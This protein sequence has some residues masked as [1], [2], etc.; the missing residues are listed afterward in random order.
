MRDI[1]F[2]KDRIPRAQQVGLPANRYFN[3]AQVDNQIFDRTG[4]VRFCVLSRV[5]FET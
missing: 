1:G 2:K 3:S 5:T 4:R